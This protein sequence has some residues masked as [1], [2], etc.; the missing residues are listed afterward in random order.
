[1]RYVRTQ[2]GIYE[3]RNKRIEGKKITICKWGYDCD[4]D[5]GIIE[6][7]ELEIIA[8]ADTIEELCEGFY[9]ETNGICNF[10]DRFFRYD[11]YWDEFRN[12]NSI[13]G[14]CISRRNNLEFVKTLKGF[15]KTDKG[16]VF[17]SKMNEQGRAELL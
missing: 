10:V 8:Q 14:L 9:A 15:I 13:S 7:K 12:M 6:T 11:A 16:F 1:M 3:T 2:D 5:Y 17:V 4:G